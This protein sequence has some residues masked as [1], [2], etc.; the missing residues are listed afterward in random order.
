[1]PEHLLFES[2]KYHWPTAGNF[3]YSLQ[4]LLHVLLQ[5]LCPAVVT[6]AWDHSKHGCFNTLVSVMLTPAEIWHLNSSISQIIIIS[7]QADLSLSQWLSCGLC[8]KHISSNKQS[9]T[10]PHRVVRKRWWAARLRHIWSMPFDLQF[11]LFWNLG[12]KQVFALIATGAY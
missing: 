2:P 3:L 8:E 11:D 7:I 6:S 1:M 9:Q 10:T 12:F 4:L 5:Q